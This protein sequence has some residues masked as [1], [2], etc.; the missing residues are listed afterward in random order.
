MSQQSTS[1][2]NKVVLITGA[3]SGIGLATVE[4]LKDV[5]YRP[6]LTGRNPDKVKSCAEKLNIP[7]YQ[8]NV[9]SEED[10]TR[11]IEAVEQDIGPI[12]GLVN[13]AGIWLEGSFEDYS[14]ADIRTVMETNTLGTM[15]M[16]HAIL[17]NMLSRKAGAIINVVSTGALYCRK[18]ISVYAGSKWAIR[19]FTGCMEV[20]CAPK[21]VRVMG[22]YPGKVDTNMYS[23][24]GIDRDLE[25][26]MTPG[27][28]ASMIERM[29]TDEKIL[30]GHISGRSIN[31]YQ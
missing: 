28:A 16:T 26:A 2:E 15:F 31:D 21:G 25:V 9:A 13:N 27:D 24:A 6:V 14:A 10:C 5:G 30:W 17:P 7:G 8:L 1:H 3:T 4:K 22:F 18:S 19:G 29:L 12:W 20:E 11:I 23:T